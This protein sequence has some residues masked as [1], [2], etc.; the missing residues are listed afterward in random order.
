MDAYTNFAELK[1]A[2]REGADFRVYVQRRE[3]TSI[4]VLAPHGGRIEPG[5]SEV[6]EKIAGDDLS[7]AL[8]EGKKSAGNER[9]HITSTN[10]DE[11]RCVDLAQASDTVLAIHGEGSEE[12]VVFL[13]GRDIDLRGQIG[14]ILRKTGYGVEV[15]ENPGLQGMA[16]AN[17]C[18]RGRQGAGVQLELSLG[19][20]KTFFA[21]LRVEGRKKPT[22]ELFRF[23]AA[24]REGIRNGAA[25]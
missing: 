19:L 23:T 8:F 6:A 13:G 4:A 14:D 11:P 2:E 12:P 1:E 20:R 7:L 24:V 21:S 22:D 9:L 17:I 10:F 18:N 25:L 15:H 5:T 3:G 16:M